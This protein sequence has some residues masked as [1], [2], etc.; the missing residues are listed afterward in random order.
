VEGVRVGIDAAAFAES[1]ARRAR[2]NA[3]PVET[4]VGAGD[5]AGAAAL[6]IGLRVDAFVFLADE[7]LTADADAVYAV[8]VV[9]AVR[10]GRAA[11]RGI[12][13]GEH[14]WRTIG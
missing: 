13:I 10:L 5:A 7:P 8:F 2:R 4:D 9:L 12:A 14:R 11:A 1:S 3:L 6:T